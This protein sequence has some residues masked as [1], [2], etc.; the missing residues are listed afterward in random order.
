MKMVKTNTEN[1]TQKACIK[2]DCFVYEKD[3][4]DCKVMTELLCARKKCSFYKP[5]ERSDSNAG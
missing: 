5:K 3:K 4:R 1:M 2:T